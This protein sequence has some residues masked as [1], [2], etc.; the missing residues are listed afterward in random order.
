MGA[1]VAR[2]GRAALGELLLAL[3]ALY[4]VTLALLLG[5]RCRF[6]PSCSEYAAESIRNLGPLRGSWRTLVRLSKCHPF[7]PGGFDPP[8][9]STVGGSPRPA[10]P[11]KA[12]RPPLME[13]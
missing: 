1:A 7:H 4:R 10:A 13:P 12:A 11:G 6:T 3:I 8:L 9:P 5:G 2:L